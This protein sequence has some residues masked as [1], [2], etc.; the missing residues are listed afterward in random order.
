MTNIRREAESV[1]G[2]RARK[3]G[4]TFEVQRADQPQREQRIDRSPPSEALLFGRRARFIEVSFV[5]S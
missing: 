3:L 2:D 4:R 5:S 1:A